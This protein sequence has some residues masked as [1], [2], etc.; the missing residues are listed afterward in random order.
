MQDKEAA[1]PILGGD[2]LRPGGCSGRGGVSDK[3]MSKEGA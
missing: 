2:L 1:G 3:H